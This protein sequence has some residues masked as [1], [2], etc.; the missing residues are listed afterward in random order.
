MPMLAPPT[1][2]TLPF[3]PRS[4]ASPWR[5]DLGKEALGVPM[6]D[7][8]QDLLRIA[9]RLPVAGEPVVGEKRIVAAEH[10]AIL[11]ASGDLMLEVGRVVSGRPAVQL[12]PDIALVHEHR[13]HLGLPR[14]AGARRNDLELGIARRDQIEV[15]RMAIIEDDAVAAWQSGAETGG[16]DEDEYRNAGLDTEPV[17]GRVGRI[18]RRRRQRGGDRIAEKADPLI[19]AAA[20]LLDPVGAGARR[21]DVDPVPENDI[22][23]RA[24]G[25]EGVVVQ[26]PRLLERPVFGEAEIKDGA[27]GVGA[28][29]RRHLA[30]A[31]IGGLRVPGGALLGEFRFGLQ[32]VAASR[33]P[34]RMQVDDLHDVALSPSASLSGAMT[35]A[36]AGRAVRWLHRTSRAAGSSRP[37][38]MS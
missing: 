18:A 7:L 14:P 37:D 3:R 25:V 1:I 27:H 38:R 12:V 10:D 36:S 5:P 23:V 16:A 8:L 30:L 33:A 32:R 35:A 21:I 15:A 24:L 9:F 20:Q 11:E 19:D 31:M 4:M 34:M 17:V 29:M 2:A 22:A 26:R 6:E 13:D 28:K